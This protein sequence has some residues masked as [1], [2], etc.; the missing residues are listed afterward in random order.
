MM[1]TDSNSKPG[2]LLWLGL[3]CASVFPILFGLRVANA[4]PVPG[5]D[6]MIGALAA[7]CVFTSLVGTVVG[8][9]HAARGGVLAFLSVCLGVSSL[10]MIGLFAFVAI[11]LRD[12]GPS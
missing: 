7:T 2:S 9:R 8:A 5:S 11:A 1:S 12:F 6:V 10:L 3:G 4:V